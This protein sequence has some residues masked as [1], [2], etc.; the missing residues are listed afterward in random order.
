MSRTRIV[1]N[2]DRRRHTVSRERLDCGLFGA[3]VHDS[4]VAATTGLLRNAREVAPSSALL[5][6]RCGSLLADVLRLLSLE[7]VFHGCCSFPSS[8]EGT[9][10]IKSVKGD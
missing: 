4:C 3:E 1:N 9:R 7:H 2:R 5:L 10:Q 8:R 6:L